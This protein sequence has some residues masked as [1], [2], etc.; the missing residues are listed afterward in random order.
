MSNL[1]Q[2]LVYPGWFVSAPYEG[3][4]FHL[5]YHREWGYGFKHASDDEK[6]LYI[7]SCG[8]WIKIGI[9]GMPI[10]RLSEIQCSNPEKVNLEMICKP[11]D[12]S[13]RSCESEMHTHFKKYRGIGE[14]FR[15]SCLD[16]F[17]Q[18]RHKQKIKPDWWESHVQ[19][20]DAQMDGYAEKHPYWDRPGGPCFSALRKDVS[21]Q[22]FQQ[23]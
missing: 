11:L 18:R 12:C 15:R 14:W 1:E 4:A 19:R 16:L 3:G 8:D 13:A 17:P 7:M 23:P 9:A 5:I 6:L 22:E 2:Q 20:L 21:S 10:S